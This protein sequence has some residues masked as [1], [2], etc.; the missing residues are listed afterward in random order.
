MKKGLLSM[1]F[2]TAF[3][4]FTIGQVTYIDY[5]DV[6]VNF[7][8]WGGST[9]S[10]DINP[11]PSGINT[12]D[13]VGMIVKGGTLEEWP[14]IYS[15]PLGGTFDFSSSA[16]FTVKVYSDNTGPFILKLEKA[17]DGG[18]AV[19]AQVDYTTPGEWAELS[20][21]LSEGT[22]ETYGKIV[23]IPETNLEGSPG[24][25]WYFDDVVGPDFIPGA[26]VDV[27]FQVTDLDNASTSVEV[28]VSNDPGTKIALTNDGTGVWTVTETLPGNTFKDIYTYTLYVDGTAVEDVTDKNLGVAAGA[29][30]QTVTYTFGG[31][32]TDEAM[33]TY[34]GTE[35]LE[36]DGEIDFAWDAAA[37]YPISLPFGA[38]TFEDEAD[39]NGYFKVGWDETGLYLLVDV[40]DDYLYP[41]GEFGEAWEKDKIEVYIDMNVGNLEDAA[42]PGS[43]DN[44]GTN[45]HFQLAPNFLADYTD[46]P[47]W[48]TGDRGYN[49]DTDTKGEPVNAVTEFWIPWENLPDKD[50]N[51]I[52][53]DETMTFGLGISIADNDGP[54]NGNARNR[55]VWVNASDPESWLNMDACGTLM[56]EESTLD[57]EAVEAAKFSVYPNPASDVLYVRNAVNAKSVSVHNIVGAEVLN[58]TVDGSETFSINTSDLEKG[59]YVIS[60]NTESGS[61]GHTKFVV[62]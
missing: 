40:N 59:I 30:T 44:D 35:F 49:A 54:D 2:L 17:D 31:G 12:S 53:P 28:E 50:G 45:G 10:V 47:T 37:E 61:A 18:V 55:M 32:L 9:F 38:E 3:G 34:F 56:L 51:V 42:G 29:G 58:V 41:E 62:E 14:G 57:V 23:M 27:T 19:E 13:N 33:A 48:F 8:G 21:D 39:C 52:V 60:V 16:I 20:F 26:D 25:V 24:H 1:L 4:L 36:I 46:G 6:S 5:E 11:D 15:D 22:T 43:S 7:G